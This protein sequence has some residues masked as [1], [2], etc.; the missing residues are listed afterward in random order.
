VGLTGKEVYLKECAVCH[1]KEGEGTPRGYQVRF[2]VSSYATLVTRVGRSGNRLFDIP[3]PGYSA[4]K[5]SDQQ[6]KEIWEYLGSFPHPTQ[7]KELFTAY[8]AN[9]HGQD[10]RGGFSGE[11]ILG[12]TGEYRKYIRRG[13]NL[14]YPLNR[15]KYMP[16]YTE[17]ELSANDILL[18]RQYARELRQT[19]P[20]PRPEPSPGP[21]SRPTPHDDDDDDH[22]DEHR[23]E[24]KP[25]NCDQKDED[26]DED[27]DDD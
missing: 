14:R 19:V 18:L 17:A 27:E 25:C 11:S 13:K 1:G 9:C 16:A 26:E 24:K 2:P 5:I 12:E 7:G 15:R 6:L 20:R 8:C 23:H 3:M 22:D 21:V 4:E 10:G